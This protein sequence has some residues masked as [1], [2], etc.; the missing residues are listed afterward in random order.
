MLQQ[1]PV[2]TLEEHIKLRRL[3]RRDRIRENSYHLRCRDKQK[4]SKWAANELTAS[5]VNLQ[6]DANGINLL[7]KESTCLKRQLGDEFAPLDFVKI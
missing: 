7:S 6:H 3:S 5:V 1:Q 2:A 4:K